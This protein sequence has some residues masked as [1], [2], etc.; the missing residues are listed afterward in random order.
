MVRDYTT[1]AVNLP[2]QV[3]Y[4]RSRIVVPIVLIFL[5]VQIFLIVLIIL[6]ILI[7]LIALIV[8]II[9]IA[10][11]ILIVLIA[12]IE[13]IGLI[14]IPCNYQGLLPPPQELIRTEFSQ[15]EVL[16]KSAAFAFR[17]LPGDAQYA[18]RSNIGITPS[19][20]GV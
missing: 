12:L 10:L 2:I 19:A 18:F 9:L 3:K 20:D 4:I 5:I 6:I 16:S 17:R 11:I 1:S 8:Q 15:P 14:K 13:L 7:I